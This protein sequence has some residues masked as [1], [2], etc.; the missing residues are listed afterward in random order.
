MKLK[1][2]IA[3]LSVLAVA[4]LSSCANN[5][6]EGDIILVYEGIEYIQADY[7]WVPIGELL[8]NKQPAYINFYE[9]G[10]SYNPDD[11]K[12]NTKIQRYTNDTSNIFILKVG[13]LLTEEQLYIR[14]DAK[15]P[16]MATGSVVSKIILENQEEKIVY[17]SQKTQSEIL[18]TIAE[19][20]KDILDNK[21][22]PKDGWEIAERK[23]GPP[24]WLNIYYSD[25]PAYDA[26][27]TISYTQD[28]RIG[29][30]ASDSA[31]N[32]LLFGNPSSLLLLSEN[33]VS[34][35]IKSNQ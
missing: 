6:T 5:E 9:T 30:E 35:I 32:N 4:T 21:S 3:I 8:D 15:Y 18:E 2:V 13:T 31:T 24:M 10:T 25:F 12:E 33:A 17:L 27:W 16:N 19:L 28:G 14:E 20:Q 7:N 23:N 22:G 29:I 11:Y 34:E 26:S 1:A